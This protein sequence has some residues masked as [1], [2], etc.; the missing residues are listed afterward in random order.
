MAEEKIELYCWKRVVNHSCEA[1]KLNVET[2]H[3][4]LQTL[5]QLK[6]LAPS[7]QTIRVLCMVIEADWYP[8]CG[9]NLCSDM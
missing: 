8:D 3:A 2:S 6:E 5:H 4:A 9:G 1:L 7:I